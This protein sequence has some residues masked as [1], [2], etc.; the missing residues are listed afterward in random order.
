MGEEKDW[1]SGVGAEG[2]YT[3]CTEGQ[4]NDILSATE[5]AYPLVCDICDTRIAL[6]CE[7]LSSR[8]CVRC[9]YLER[10]SGRRRV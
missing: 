8:E 6:G 4:G 5:E 9:R 1:R 10:G 7:W 2:R 3:I